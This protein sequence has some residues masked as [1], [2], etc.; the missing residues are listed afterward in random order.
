MFLRWCAL[1]AFTA[2]GVGCAGAET[3]MVWHF[4]GNWSYNGKEVKAYAQVDPRQLSL[5]SGSGEMGAFAYCLM[6]AAP[7]YP[8]GA[9]VDVFAPLETWVAR[10]AGKLAEK[11]EQTATIYASEGAK[12]MV[13]ASP[14]LGH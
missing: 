2:L 11:P 5:R 6:N 12:R 7:E 3:G 10:E 9:V 8:Q 1:A 13:L 14:K 4:V